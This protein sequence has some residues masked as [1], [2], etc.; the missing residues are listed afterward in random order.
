MHLQECVCL[1][2]LRD[3]IMYIILANIL[4]IF[5]VYTLKTNKQADLPLGLSDPLY[6]YCIICSVEEH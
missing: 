6:G 5:R 1:F 2:F 4:K 3:L